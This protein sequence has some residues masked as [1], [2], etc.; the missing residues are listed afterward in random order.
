MLG[1]SQVLCHMQLLALVLDPSLLLCVISIKQPAMQQRYAVQ[2]GQWSLVWFG[3]KLFDPAYLTIS[4][5]FS[6]LDSFLYFFLGL[7]LFFSVGPTSF[8]KWSKKEITSFLNLCL[9]MW[10][11]DAATWVNHTHM[12]GQDWSSY[13]MLTLLQIRVWLVPNFVDVCYF[14]GQ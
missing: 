6:V 5:R 2:W 9:M 1:K 11:E 7:L 12:Y 10:G 4:M 14:V 3:S 13:P 8:L